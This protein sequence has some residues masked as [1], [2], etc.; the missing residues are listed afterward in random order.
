MF[1]V[2]KVDVLDMLDRLEIRNVHEVRGGEVNFS[3]PYPAHAAGD[4]SPS[5]YMN[6]HTTAYFCHA[7]HAKG[8]AI[9][10]ASDILGIS[11]I[12]AIRFL[13]ETY[14]PAAFDPDSR[15]SEAELQ[16]YRSKRIEAQPEQWEIRIDEEYNDE[17]VIDWQRAWD[18]DESE[19]PEV[20]NYIFD[21]GFHPEALDEFELGHD[22]IYDRLCFPVRDTDG[23]L[24]GLKGRAYRDG[25]Q[26]KYLVLGD[27]TG[28]RPRFGFPRYNVSRVVFGANKIYDQIKDGFDNIPIII[29]EGELNVV[30]LWQKGFDNAVAVNGSNL[31]ERQ[32]YILRAIA[33]EVTI[34]FD[35]DDAGYNGAANV[36][37]ALRQY[38]PIKMVPDHEKD[39][40][41]LPREEIVEI[42][43][44]ALSIRQLELLLRSDQR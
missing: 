10:F 5:A 4:E 3:C 16:R 24:I 23:D 30:S 2:E 33:G 25:Q 44:E 27:E 17:R 28:K 41:D 36:A 8:N 20:I 18:A 32:A 14:D 40:A 12:K 22:H 35:S 31:S 21:R 37:D 11:R 15:S 6:L 38:M 1:D 26:P 7:C 19:R 13:R 42:L 29:C 39:P 34:F 9:R 43:D